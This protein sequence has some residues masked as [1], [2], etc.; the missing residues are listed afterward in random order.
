MSARESK[1][2]PLNSLLLAVHDVTLRPVIESDLDALG[3][4]VPDDL[5]MNPETLRPFGLDVAGTRAVALRQEYWK[6]LGAW[7]P[8]DWNLF[9]GVWSGDDLVGMQGLEGKD[10]L[11]LRTVETWSWLRPKWRGRGLGK[12]ART[13]VLALAF[14]GLEAQI[15]LTEAWAD[16]DASLGVSTSIGYV[17]NGSVL[18]KRDDGTAFEMP[19][20]RLDIDG[21]R[22]VA[23]PRVVIEGLGPCLPWFGVSHPS[24]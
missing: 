5:E 19:R 10:F 9:L 1:Y 20:M 17:P 4:V 11:V 7:T 6:T 21:W 13:A 18:H 3:D 12:V 15:A 24:E 2:W 23:R 14:D 22:A 16:N 8:D